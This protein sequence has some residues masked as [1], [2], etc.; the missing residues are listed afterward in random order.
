MIRILDGSHNGTGQGPNFPANANSRASGGSGHGEISFANL[1]A[2][3][4]I[5][6][7]PEPAQHIDGPIDK[8][9]RTLHAG[10][11]Q[12]I[13]RPSGLG[14]KLEEGSKDHDIATLQSFLTNEDIPLGTRFTLLNSRMQLG[15]EVLL[16]DSKIKSLRIPVTEQSRLEPLMKLILKGDPLLDEQTVKNNIVANCDTLLMMALEENYSAEQLYNVLISIKNAFQAVD[17]KE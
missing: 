13:A 2:K 7:S 3:G 4:Y 11:Q 14:V 9:L 5:G 12:E 10:G 6:P 1:R 16:E 17:T 8:A 15:Y